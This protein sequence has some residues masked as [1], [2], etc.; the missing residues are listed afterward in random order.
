MTA[1]TVDQ[2]RQMGLDKETLRLDAAYRTFVVRQNH[3]RRNSVVAQIEV[4]KGRYVVVARMDLNAG[5]PP[6]VTREHFG[7][8]GSTFPISDEER[9]LIAA[10]LDGYYAGG[11]SA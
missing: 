10:W 6:F 9:P 8:D 4:G 1:I 5:A 7:R 2:A 11:G 3:A